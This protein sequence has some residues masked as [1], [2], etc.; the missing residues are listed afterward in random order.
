VHIDRKSLRDSRWW[1]ALSLALLH[2]SSV[3]FV[4]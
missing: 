3:W 2:V 1:I 4:V